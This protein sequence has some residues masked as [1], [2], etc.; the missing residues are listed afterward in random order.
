MKKILII[1]IIVLLVIILAFLFFFYM[2]KNKSMQ[3]VQ[4]PVQSVPQ[5]SVPVLPGSETAKVDPQ[6]ATQSIQ[7][8]ISKAETNSQETL[9]TKFQDTKNQS[10]PLEQFKTATSI[11]IK[12]EIYSNLS[13]TD[14]SVFTCN[15]KTENTKGLGLITRFK[16]GTAASHYADLYKKI[17]K[18]LVNW[19][20]II[21]SDL[22]SLLFPGKI[23]SQKPAFKSTKYTTENGI[24]NMDI[25]YANMK[26][27][28]G[29]NFSIDYTVFE[30][31]VY[32]FNNPQCLRKALD[33]YE[34]VAEP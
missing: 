8:N 14:Y 27:D 25:R 23:F 5:I 16:P 31:N 20:P 34:P 7:E 29:A 1:G 4:A 28:D 18:S 11:T 19:E 21:F 3:N 13:Q 2:T 10:L 15:L 26:S 33:K 22:A 6:N 32:I 17:N 12:P 24:A 9:D 30:E